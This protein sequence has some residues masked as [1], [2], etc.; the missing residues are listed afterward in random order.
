MQNLDEHHIMNDQSA[1]YKSTT[2]VLIGFI[3]QLVTVRLAKPPTYLSINLSIRAAKTQS[4][5]SGIGGSSSP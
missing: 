5:G 4:G 3:S 1:C 2:V